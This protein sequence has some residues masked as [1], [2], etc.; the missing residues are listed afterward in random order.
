MKLPAVT[1]MAHK[2]AAVAGTFASCR[3]D[4]DKNSIAIKAFFLQT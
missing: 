3:E 1:Q 4:I 2:L